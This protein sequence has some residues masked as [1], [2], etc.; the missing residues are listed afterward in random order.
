MS[1]SE[2]LLV[3]LTGGHALHLSGI[4]N[5]AKF[6]FYRAKFRGRAREGHAPKEE[7]TRSISR[8]PLA[9]VLEIFSPTNNLAPATRC[10]FLATLRETRLFW[11]SHDAI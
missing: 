4:E 1:T 8:V 9:R 6:I 7:A 2:L 11:V 3:V 10:K 5:K